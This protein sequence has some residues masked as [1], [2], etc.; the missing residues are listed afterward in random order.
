MKFFISST[1][2]DLYDFRKKIQQILKD[3][4]QE[5][6]AFEEPSFPVRPNLHSHDQC[7]EAVKDA[8]FIICIL[9]KRYGGKY[10]GNDKSQ[11]EDIKLDIIGCTP[12]GK[13]K[14]YNKIIKKDSLSITWCE[15]VTAQDYGKEIFTF[16][17]KKLFDEKE[18]RRRNQFLKSFKPAYAEKEELFDLIDWI[19][20]SRTNN[21]ITPFDSIVDFELYFRKWLKEIVKNRYNPSDYID[22]KQDNELITSKTNITKSK[23]KNATIILFCVEAESD[24]EFITSILRKTNLNIEARFLVTY[25]KYRM[26][27]E[28]TTYITNKGEID[29]FFILYDTDNEDLSKINSYNESLKVLEGFAPV[30]IFPIEPDIDKWINAGM[31][32]GKHNKKREFQKISVDI[33]FDIELAKQEDP[34]FADFIEKLSN[35]ENLDNRKCEN[36]L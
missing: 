22:N 3:E 2:Y 35:Y 14:K 6:L 34:S 17:R 1:A 5:C 27:H 21:W 25:G 33:E 36:N 20:K 18:V 13:R 32:Q 28:L 26:F 30:E 10:A 12:S 11:F 29:V 15:L 7:I 31:K 23:E 4:G 8:D 24:R 16:V 9:D 19:T